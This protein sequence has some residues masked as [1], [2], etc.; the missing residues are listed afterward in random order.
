MTYAEYQA[1]ADAVA[2]QLEAEFVGSAVIGLDAGPDGVTLG[3][4][5]GDRDTIQARAD[6]LYRLKMTAA[7]ATAK[8]A[9]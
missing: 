3:A 1:I 5:S 4:V 9:S 2:I 6:E 8:A 7:G